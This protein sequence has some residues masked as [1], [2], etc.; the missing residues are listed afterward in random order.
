MSTRRS[1]LSAQTTREVRRQ[2]NAYDRFHDAVAGYLRVNRTDLRCLDLLDQHGRQTAGE[3]AEATGLTTGAVTA[4]IDRLERA[5][6]VQR[7]RDPGDRRRVLV[8]ATELARKYA[9]QVYAP[10]AE[11]AAPLYDR[12]SE[13][14]MLTI[15]DFLRIVNDFYDTQIA[16]VEALDRGSG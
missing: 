15:L 7:L 6:Y 14:Q 10:L 9:M 13:Q 3:L 5:G 11:Q 4:M 1:T 16:R 2:Q 12:F 8:E